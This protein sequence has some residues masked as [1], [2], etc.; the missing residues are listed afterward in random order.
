MLNIVERPAVAMLRE[1]L[2]ST[3]PPSATKDRPAHVRVGITLTANGLE[4]MGVP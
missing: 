2:F 3:V 1:L 4:G